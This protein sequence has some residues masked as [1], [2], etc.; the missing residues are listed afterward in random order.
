MTSTNKRI[1]RARN[2]VHG[3]TA[4]CVWMIVGLVLIG[5]FTFFFV[6]RYLTS[7]PIEKA[8]PE[9]PIVGSNQ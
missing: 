4:G 8:E 2:H 9:T 1:A 3:N 5:F 6:L 7:S